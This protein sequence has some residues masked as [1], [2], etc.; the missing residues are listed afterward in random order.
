[1]LN[2]SLFRFLHQNYIVVY[3]FSEAADVCL[4]VCVRVCARVCVCVCV[5]V[6]LLYSLL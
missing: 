3:L 1:M 5:R 2:K 6:T 4:C